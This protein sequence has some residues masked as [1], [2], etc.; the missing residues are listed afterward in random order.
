MRFLLFSGLLVLVGCKVTA[1]QAPVIDAP[2]IWTEGV[3]TTSDGPKG[4]T[5]VSEVSPW[6]TRCHDPLLESLV[7]E[8][9]ASGPD[10]QIAAARVKEADLRWQATNAGFGPSLDFSRSLRRE[11]QS[12]QSFNFGD[13]TIFY[14]IGSIPDNSTLLLASF[15]EASFRFKKRRRNC[16][17]GYNCF[18]PFT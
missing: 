8:A 14:M 5:S 15:C 7:D 10:I 13:D 17:S 3:A 11:D 9:M 1:P 18:D 16:G 4:E 12:S 2:G 6:W